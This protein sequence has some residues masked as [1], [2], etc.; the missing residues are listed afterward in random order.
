M[1][2]RN[3]FC[4]FLGLVT[5]FCFLSPLEPVAAQE[6]VYYRFSPTAIY[7]NGSDST[8]LEIYTS[9]NVAGVTLKP[10]FADEPVY[11]LYDDGSNGDAVA[12]D[13]TF[14]LGSITSTMFPE[15]LLF[16]IAWNENN[17][18]VDL[19]TIWLSIEISYGSGQS[20][21]ISFMELRVVSSKLEFAADQVGDG[22]Y[23]SEYAIFIV[24][25]AGETYTGNFPNI[26][27]YD[28]PSIAKKF[29]AIYP[30]EFDFINFMVVRGD[31]GMKA[32]SGSLR[33][34]ATNIGTDQPDYTAE[35]GSQGRLLAMT[36]SSFGFL[37]H[38]IGHSWGAFVGVEQG[39]STG[40]H[41]SGSTDISGMM[42]EGYETSDG[43]Y[44][45]TPN[46]D[47]TFTAGWFEDRFAP[48]ELYLMGMIPPEEVPDVQILHDLDLSDL[49]RVVPGSIETYSIE[50]IM[51]AA[52]GPRQPAYPAAQ[53]DFNIA[54]VLL[55][56][57]N[58]SEAE[59]ALY[60]FLSREYSAQREAN[61]LENFYTATGRLGTVNTRLA[62]WGI[63]GIQP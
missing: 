37:N 51:A 15:D 17:V 25:P 57:S 16:P 35:F 36:Y 59:I 56:D 21:L 13:G 62:D 60:S 44:F 45:F 28:G 61:A 18:D 3:L 42:S 11:Q 10:E 58:F 29:Y 63:P 46:G 39:I 27:D 20:E 31:L 4:I 6:A 26:T 55:S 19:A 54:I 22:L 48:L 7:D 5:I 1:K 30:D 40:I 23:A 32:H 8:T 24:D 41:W 49:E 2:T 9:G 43:L 53:T 52:G 14:T 12:G 38:E 33:S 47:G 34:A 50:Q